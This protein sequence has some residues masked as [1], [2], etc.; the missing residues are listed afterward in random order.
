MVER[1]QELDAAR[2]E[3]V[4][5][6]GQGEEEMRMLAALA[7]ELEMVRRQARGQATRMRLRALQD[8]AELSRRMTRLADG[9]GETAE[10]LTRSLEEAIER[11]GAADE[12]EDDPLAPAS[13]GHWEREPGE[14]FEGLVEVDVGP[15]SD[16]SQ[17]VGFE[18]AAAGI[19]ATSEV[20]VK[21]FTRGRATLA[22]RFKQPVELLSE[23]EERAPFEFRVRDTRSNRVVLD[24]GE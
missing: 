9:P 21:R 24:V 10:R 16:F 8:A 18:D 14:L 13:N 12:R 22:M 7:E 2:A 17:L 19:G 20:S 15:L 11:I 6:R 5:L 1:G 4:A 23:L 3:L